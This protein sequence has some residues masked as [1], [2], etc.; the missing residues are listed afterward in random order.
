MS[1]QRRIEYKSAIYH[2]IQRGSNREDIFEGDLYKGYLIKMIKETKG[3]HGFKFY[4]YVIMDNHYHLIIQT[5]DTPISKI[6]HR[7]NSQY[8]RYY[9]YKEKRTGPVFQNRYKGILVK[10]ERY[11]LQ[12][13]KY[14]H[15][16]PVKAKM[17]SSM[18]KYKWSSDVFY[19]RNMKNVVDTDGILDIIS[20]NRIEAIKKYIDFMDGEY[21]HREL[22]PDIFENMQVIGS[23]KFKEEMFTENNEEAMSLEEILREVCTSETE[24]DLIKSASRKRYLTD[25]KSEYVKRARKLHYSFADIGEYI[26]ISDVAAIKLWER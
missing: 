22:H 9:N 5:L 19:R 23:S 10:D 20:L 14:I 4:G 16:N 17:C 11:L 13:L 18:D 1:R 24:Y 2:L 12:L 26:G 21:S 7:I 15:L 8:A 3:K 6:M 25:Y